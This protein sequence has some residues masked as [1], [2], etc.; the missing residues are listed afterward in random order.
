M[1]SARFDSNDSEPKSQVRLLFLLYLSW[2]NFLP[3]R[4]LKFF[5]DTLSK[6]F[7]HFPYVGTRTN[8][9]REEAFAGPQS[10]RT[11]K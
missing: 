5:R 3:R 6:A 2:A 4:K 1:E 10:E 9:F 7:Y 8:V 11:I